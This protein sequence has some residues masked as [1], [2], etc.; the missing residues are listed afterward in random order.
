MKNQE[1]L[2]PVRLA[3]IRS[4]GKIANATSKQQALQRMESYNETPNHCL[5]CNRAILIPSEKMNRTGFQ[6][7][8][9][10]KFC[11]Q[12]CG[13]KYNMAKNLIPR[14]RLKLR[15]CVNCNNTFTK[16]KEHR[17]SNLRCPPCVLIYNSTLSLKTKA[18]CWITEIR[19]HARA[20]MLKTK[21]AVCEIC[22]YSLHVDCC[23]INPIKKFPS[24]TL[25]AEVN[26][27]SNLAALCKN[28]HWELDHGLLT[29]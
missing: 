4:A 6:Q 8:K 11:N 10:K 21:P 13:A 9:Q 14:N 15:T 7:I 27:L 22:G 19:R 20:T 1:P 12:S 17:S 28:H 23:H 16:T 2:H 29:L 5:Q 3:Q 18:E 24:T 25:I 26:A